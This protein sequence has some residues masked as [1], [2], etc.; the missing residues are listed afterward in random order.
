MFKRRPKT[1]HNMPDGAPRSDASMTPEE[2][3]RTMASVT[4]MTK[5]LRVRTEGLTIVIFAI[6]MLASYL[7]LLAPILFAGGD[8]GPGPRGG[9]DFN[10]STFNGTDFRDRPRPPPTQFFL[11][12][13]APLVWYI[14]AA[15]TTIGIWRGASLSFQT[16]F[17]TPRIVAVFVGW[18]IVFA[19]LITILAGNR[20]TLHAWHLIAWGVVIGLFATLNPLRFTRPGRV[21]AGSMAIV[22]LLAAVYAFTAALPARDIGFLTGVALGLPGLIGGLWL[23]YRG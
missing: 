8:G 4:S 7:T 21:A 23:L 12:Q 14:I 9:F 3:V 13:Y 10:N 20:T 19:V 11:S 22:A 6:C 2:A 5:G 1:H 18:L 17:S 16:G 15:V